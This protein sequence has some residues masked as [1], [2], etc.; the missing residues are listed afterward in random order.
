MQEM[1][2]MTL[3]IWGGHIEKPLLDFIE[4]H[5]ETDIFCFQEVYHNAPYKMCDDDIGMQFSLNLFSKL[6]TLLPKHNAF[7]NPVIEDWY[8]IGIFIKKEITVLE[9]GEVCI[10]SNPN[11]KGRGPTHDRTLQWLTCSKEGAIFTIIN[12]HGLWNGKGK[13][14][15]PERLDQSKKIRE[16]MDS[17]ST[18]KI[19]CGDFNLRPDTESLKVLEKGMKNLIDTYGITSTRTSLYPKQEKFADYIFTS[20]EIMVQNFKILEDEVS[21]HA[22]LVVDFSLKK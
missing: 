20:G 5:Q 6:Q 8:G 11:Y 9:G 21:D 10:H 17:L 3:N 7:F 1:R 19:L 18:P 22:P 12:V 16:F 14:D 2:L 15:T 13:T 4:V